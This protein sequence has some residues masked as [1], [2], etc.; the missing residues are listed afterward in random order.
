MRGIAATVGALVLGAGIGASCAEAKENDEFTVGQWGGYSYTDDNNGQFTDCTAWATNRDNVQIGVSVTKTWGL[1]L[2]LYAKSWNLPDGQS[3]PV[4][5]WI[6]RGAQYRGKA[7]TSGK[8]SVLI[9]VDAG[10]EV[11][12]ALKAGSELTVRTSSDD[13]VFDLSGSRAALGRLIDCV[14]QYTKAATSNPFGPGSGS[15]DGGNQQPSSQQPDN[16]GGD[17]GGLLADPTVSVDDVKRFIV[18]VTGAKPSTISAEAKQDKQ[19]GKYYV[20]TTPLGE[21]QF[22]QRNLGSS[23]LDDMASGYVAKYRDDCKGG[24]EESANKPVQ[25]PHA[26][27]VSGTA[28]CAR[29]PY[30]NDG[31]EFISYSIIEDESGVLSY[32]LTYTGGNA[33]KAKSD[34]LGR[35]IE[36]RYEDLLQQD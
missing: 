6:D 16:Q 26:H 32:Y 1:Q 12:Q 22:W 33:A 21:G 17:S 4:S 14:D 2:W 15:D 9:A 18:E 31:P 23:S 29:S 35:L 24:F 19:G 20:F 10:D 36:R 28:A 7:V 3:Y 34:S 25:G 11:F 30:Q 5:Y 8:Q 13:Y 27:L